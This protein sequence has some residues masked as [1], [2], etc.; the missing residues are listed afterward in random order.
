MFDNISDIDG[1]GRF[2]RS[3]LYDLTDFT[4]FAMS[5]CA[6]SYFGILIWIA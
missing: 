6:V 1:M 3:P 4:N 2:F 5:L